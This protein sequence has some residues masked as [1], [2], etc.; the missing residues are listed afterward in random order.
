MVGW[1]G[2]GMEVVDGMHAGQSQ[3]GWSHV[4]RCRSISRVR[5]DTLMIQDNTAVK[6]RSSGHGRVGISR[7]SGKG[8]NTGRQEKAAVRCPCCRLAT[9]HG[10][11][12]TLMLVCHY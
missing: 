5:G 2:T 1:A 4:C 3:G 9:L 7:S 11:P 12:R 10:A 8:H 6:V